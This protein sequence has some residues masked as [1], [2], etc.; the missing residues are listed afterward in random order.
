MIAVILLCSLVHG[1]RVFH[2]QFSHCAGVVG[3]AVCRALAL[4]GQK[5]IVLEQAQAIGTE[6]SSRNSEV[7]HSGA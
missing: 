5:V 2:R 7:I 6:T 3:L 4:E 1:V